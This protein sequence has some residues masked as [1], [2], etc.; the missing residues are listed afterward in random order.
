VEDHIEFNGKYRGDDK[1]G[2]QS[3]HSA[4]FDLIDNELVRIFNLL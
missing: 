1:D 2:P 4:R 3:Y